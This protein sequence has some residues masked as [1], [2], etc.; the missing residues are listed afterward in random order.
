MDNIDRAEERE[1]VADFTVEP[2]S[3]ENEHKI[4][5]SNGISLRD[6][7]SEGIIFQPE[8]E[9]DSQWKEDQGSH[10]FANHLE[11]MERLLEERRDREK[12]TEAAAVEDEDL[13]EFEQLKKKMKDVTESRDGGVLKKVVKVGYQTEGSVPAGA[14]VTLHYSLAL[15]GQDEP[16]DSS[17]LRGRSERYKLSEGQLIEGMEIG[18]RTMKKNEKAMFMINWVYA[19]GQIG[20]PPR[21]PEEAICLGN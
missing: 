10:Y 20:C 15:E 9:D 13:T 4:R 6:L 2:Y 8:I 5:I 17:Y 7:N 14:T 16:F 19:Y 3:E 11:E 21:I 12:E 18:I 1:D